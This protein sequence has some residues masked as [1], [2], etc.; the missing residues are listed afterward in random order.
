MGILE[1]WNLSVP[2]HS[3]Y[4]SKR[5]TFNYK[6]IFIKYI[7]PYINGTQNCEI[8]GTSNTLVYVCCLKKLSKL[9]TLKC[10]SYPALL[11]CCTCS[12]VSMYI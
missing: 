11:D 9:L 7:L 2:Q 10:V 5:Q 6:S 4:G 3:I 12:Q 1:K 8:D